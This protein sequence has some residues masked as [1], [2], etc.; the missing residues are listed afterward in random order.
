M[1]TILALLCALLA[2]PAAGQEIRTKIPGG[3]VVLQPGYHS[4]PSTKIRAAIQRDNEDGGFV[5]EIGE[6]VGPR[7]TADNLR[8]CRWSR[9]TSIDGRQVF[10]GR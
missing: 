7:L 4:V 2:L 6:A 8:L 9:K 3:T 5:S 1:K 10:M